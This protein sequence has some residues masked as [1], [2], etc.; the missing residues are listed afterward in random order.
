QLGTSRDW[1]WQALMPWARSVS[2][3]HAWGAHMSMALARAGV[4]LGRPSWVAAGAATE[5]H[6][7][8]RWA[9]IA[10]GWL[11]GDNPAGTPMYQPDS[12][13]VFDG[14]NGDRTINHNSGAESTIEGLLAL[15]NAVNDPVA[16]RYLGYDRLLAQTNY[17]K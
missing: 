3:W 11:L 8:R 9:G 4:A 15:M 17:Q 10:A 16:Q 6:F 14:I 5:N 7:F 13:V 1:P 2:D 12:G